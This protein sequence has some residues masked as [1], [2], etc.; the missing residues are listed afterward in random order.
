MKL[1]SWLT[2]TK[3][4]FDPVSHFLMIF[5]F[6]T[7]H[8]VV[9]AVASNAKTWS[10]L[11][12]PF[13]VL[14]AGATAFFF[15]LRLYDEIKDYEVDK[16]FNPGRPLVRGLVVH[17]DL[18]LGIVTCIVIELACFGAASPRAAVAVAFA[19]CYSLLMYKEFFISELIR[20]H[21]TTYAITHTVVTVLLSLSMFC[22]MTGRF[23]WELGREAYFFALNNWCLFNIFEFGRKSFCA[24][25]EREGV[26]S[27]SKI[28][29][30]FGAVLLVLSQ[31]GLGLGCIYM[32]KLPRSLTL[33]YILGGV[34][35]L[36]TISGVAYAAANRPGP[37][38]IYRA[39]SSVAIILVYVGFVVNYFKQAF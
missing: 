7:G 36:L 24:E 29:S 10:L 32:M 23:P 25:E 11:P 28:F 30:R 39:M 33:L 4:R 9:Q 37:A 6:V 35:A 34:V 38:K 18:H 27:Y 1:K 20:P 19:I 15:K 12:P 31:A 14:F 13:I 17:R 5:L 16:E 26:E 3:E 2:F 22:G 21:L 8:A